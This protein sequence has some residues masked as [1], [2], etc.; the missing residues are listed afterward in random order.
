MD[1]IASERRALGV[2]IGAVT[3]AATVLV[4]LTSG[5]AWDAVTDEPAAFGGYLAIT[6]V[7]MLLTVDIHG[8]GSI[9]LAG[10]GLLSVGFTFGVGVAAWVGIFAA[11]VHAIRRRSQVRKALFNAGT[12]AL[13][14]GAGVG[15]YTAIPHGSSIVASIGPAILAGVAFWAVNIGLLT[16]VI[17]LSQELPFFEVWNDGLRWLTLHYIAFGPL[18][19][20]SAIAYDRV[21]LAGLAFALPPALLIV[22]VRGSRPTE[23]GVLGA[24]A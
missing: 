17:S 10:I 21:G 16:L 15:A 24:A 2:L 14:A 9:S 6:A 12:F 7:L 3:A 23:P 11:L 18:A 1:R 5:R 19:L 4:V 13:A 8:R 20:A 22:A